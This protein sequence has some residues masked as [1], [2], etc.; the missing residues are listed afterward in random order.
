MQTSNIFL[1][2]L[3]SLEVIRPNAPL[4]I[5]NAPYVKAIYDLIKKP[6]NPAFSKYPLEIF[7]PLNGPFYQHL[8][9]SSDPRSRHLAENG[10]SEK[11]TYDGVI[12]VFPPIGKNKVIIIS[13]R[14]R[15]LFDSLLTL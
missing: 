9:L 15:V 7:K 1:L 14:L 11:K 3:L 8:S 5:K 6:D 2:I 12:P 13:V 4:Q 10:F